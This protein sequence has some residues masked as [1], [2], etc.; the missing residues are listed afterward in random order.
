MNVEIVFRKKLRLL[1]KER[2]HLA[3]RKLRRLFHDIAELSGHM[4]LAAPLREQGLNVENF[5]ADRGP[6]EACH[7]A[8]R[9]ILAHL[10]VQHRVRVHQRPQIVPRDGERLPVAEILYGRAAA[11]LVEAAL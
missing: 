8:G 10:A 7:N 1:R 4:N 9:R 2:L 3:D 5:A 6:G 11:E